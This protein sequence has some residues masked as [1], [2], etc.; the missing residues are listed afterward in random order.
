MDWADKILILDV[1]EGVPARSLPCLPCNP[2]MG[3]SGHAMAV[4]AMFGDVTLVQGFLNPHYHATAIRESISLLIKHRE[5]IWDLAKR[6]IADRYAGQALGTTWAIV[7]P[8]LLMGLYVFL[9]TRVFPARL[10]ASFEMP[11]SLPVYILSGLIPWLTFAD[12]MSKGTGVILAHTSLVKQIIFPLET[13]PVK[14]VL[15]SYVTQ[16]VATAM[17]FLYMLVV[18][19][20]FPWTLVL[21]PVLFAIQFFAMAG[22]CF[23]LASICVFFRDLREIVQFFTTAGLFLAPILYLPQVVEAIWPPLQLV[24][25]ANPFAHLVWCY[26]DV[27]YFG[28]IEH[29][30]SWAVLIVLSLLVFSLGYRLFRRFKGMFAE[31]L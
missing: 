31:V 8:L 3:Q 23:F 2:Q 5:L 21:L 26:Q 24:L 15:A 17:L 27:I 7:H 11:R 4:L 13:L 19:E 9:F 10:E 25:Y 16:I 20:T 14:G 29:P 18:G 6:E 1:L 28:R 30:V 22:V 12:A